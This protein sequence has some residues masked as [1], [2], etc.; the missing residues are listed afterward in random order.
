[1]SDVKF[2]NPNKDEAVKSPQSWTAFRI[3]RAW[4][5]SIRSR[6]VIS[7]L[8]LVILPL[9]VS[10]VISAIVLRRATL[11]DVYIHLSSSA[12][13]KEDSINEWVRTMEDTLRVIYHTH[14]ENAVA[15]AL[16][17]E[18]ISNG[19]FAETQDSLNLIASQT[20]VFQ[21]LFILDLYGQVIVS[22]DKT[23][24]GKL[25]DN[26]A[27][28][29]KGQADL[30][31][32]P[33]QYSQ[34]LGE[35]VIIASRP[36]RTAD[37]KV[38]GVLAGRANLAT[39]NDIML[40]DIGVGQ[41]GETYL[42]RS[43]H[44]LLT[45]SKFEGYPAGD[46]YIR[47]QGVDNVFN[48]F[49]SGTASYEGYRGTQ[50]LG[51]YRWLPDLELALVSEVEQ[52]EALQ[53]AFTSIVTNAG[54]AVGAAILAVLA[55]FFV[56]RT[57]ANPLGE[58]VGAAGRLAAG[59]LD[60]L[61]EMERQ[62]EIG[63]LANAF[64]DM[65]GQLT[66]LIGSLEERVADRTKA[67]ATSVEVSRRLSTLLDQRQLVREV[68]AQVQS[69]FNY[70]HAHIYLLNESGDELIMV[71]GTGEAGQ[72]M[73]A[74]GHKIPR[75]KG[76]VGRAAETNRPTLVPDTSKDPDWLPNPLLPETKSEV[77]VPISM[78]EQV[79]GVL[80]V[81]HN[82]VDG[83]DRE[84]A[85]LLQ[86]ISNQ[87]AIALQNARTYAE[88]QQQAQQEAL[89]SSISQKIQSAATLESVLQVAAREL[90]RALGSKETCVILESPISSFGQSERLNN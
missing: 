58:L 31:I 62:D 11:T 42:V 38:G 30:F 7:F 14:E 67:L 21:D 6:L 60:V 33:P 57:I 37:G 72:A 51:A 79:L 73:L 61:V 32:Q 41:T 43:N 80:D 23:D 54:V 74:K 40:E 28:F 39:L 22:T 56:T 36:L 20:E 68:V 1:M 4:D 18:D 70:Y 85:N 17:N 66:E 53:A 46:T 86:S 89:I 63:T 48:Q 52:D 71:G 50:V 24:I 90:G 9:L 8:A 35:I 2:E 26:Q 64:N 44:A 88:T 87:V 27:F 12:A 45:K 84:D 25:Y 55:A 3:R 49:K 10:G 82:I 77:A 34:S 78:G 15:N 76:L 69:A 19:I 65:A 81:Q 75:G 29:R 16:L 83:L 5:G 47:T 59:E 13:L